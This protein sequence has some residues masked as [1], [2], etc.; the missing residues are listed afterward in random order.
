VLFLAAA[1]GFC[2]GHLL[3]LVFDRFYT[4]EALGGPL[5][6]CSSCRTAIGPLAVIPFATV[7]TARGRCPACGE[8][9]PWRSVVLPAGGAGLFALSY[10]IF[11]EIGAGLLGGFFAT[12]FLTLTLTDLERHLLPNRIIYPS[13]IVAIAFC[14]VWPEISVLQ[15]LVGGAVAIGLAGAMFLF[16]LLFGADAF[17]LGDVKLIVLIG[18]VLGFPSVIVALFLGTILAGIVA[19]VLVVTRIRSLR[20]YI[21]HGPFLALGAVVA[22][23][24]AA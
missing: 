2:F 9:M 15:I 23:F 17:G 19:G 22:L 13:I 8:K 1:A 10:L 11:D 21:P 6:E 18:F 20:D 3:H 16:S 12:I 7:V 5:F 4:G 24:A 14:W